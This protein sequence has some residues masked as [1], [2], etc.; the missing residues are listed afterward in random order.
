[1]NDNSAATT[2]PDQ[3]PHARPL[4]ETAADDDLVRSLVDAAP[5]ALVVVDEGGFIELVNSQAEVLFG[6]RR[7]DLVGKPVEI[8]VP[9]SV[10]AV[11]RAHRTRYRADPTTRAMGAGEPLRGR[12]ADGTE[13]PVEVGLSPMKAGGRQRF[14]ASVR[15]ATNRLDTDRRNRSVRHALDAAVDGIFIVDEQT[16]K[17]TYANQQAASMHGYTVDEMIGMT[18]LHLAPDLTRESLA[19]ALSPLMAGETDAVTL[20]TSAL[21]KDGTEFPVEVH[22]NQPAATND[23]LARPLVAVVRDITERERAARVVLERQAMARVMEDRE[24]LARDLHDRV[25]GE[26]FSVGMSIQGTVPLISDAELAQRLQQSVV[27]LDDVIRLLRSTVF[28]LTGGSEGDSADR[29]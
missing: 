14:V 27:G 20:E 7:C 5:D 24:R 26:L 12:R 28:G 29:P 23:E 15:D 21:R 22:L 2:S 9:G 10:R 11:H 17:F 6:Y 3:Q 25:I 8:L 1:M 16:L 18:P 19:R 4:A 13:F